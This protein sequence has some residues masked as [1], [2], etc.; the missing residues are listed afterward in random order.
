MNNLWGSSWGTLNL[1]YQRPND[2]DIQ[3]VA[4]SMCFEVRR[5]ICDE[6]RIW[7]SSLLVIRGMGMAK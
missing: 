4:I 2:G 6:K 3:K 5:E 1:R 7:E